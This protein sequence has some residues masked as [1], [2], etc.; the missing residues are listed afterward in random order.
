MREGLMSDVGYHGFDDAGEMFKKYCSRCINQPIE[1]D[2]D[3]QIYATDCDK[4]CSMANPRYF[5]EWEQSEAEE[6]ARLWE[7]AKENKNE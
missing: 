3:G 5:E 2:A 7:E 6:E 1:Y 4:D